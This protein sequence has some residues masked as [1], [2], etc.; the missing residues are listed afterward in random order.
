MRVAFSPHRVETK[1]VPVTA[2][3]WISVL[4]SGA[5]LLAGACGGSGP[6]RPAA[7]DSFPL[8]L[9]T[10]NGSVTIPQKPSRIVSLSATATQDLYA[11]GA[12]PQVA[13][14]DKYSTYPPEAPK[15]SLSGFKPNVEAIAGY[16]P[17][18]VLVSDNT[19]DIAGQLAKLG[20]PTL[21]EPAAADFD[22]MYAQIREIGRAT[23]NAARAD[24]EATRLRDRVQSLVR[25]APKPKRAYRVYHELDQ[26]YF[27]A[28]TKTFVGQVYKQLG[29][30]D[31]ADATPGSKPYP[32]LSAEY[33]ISANP[34]LIVLADTVC[35]KQNADTVR[36]RAG[37]ASVAAVKSGAIVP[38]DDSVAS[39]W[40]P[41]IVEFV[42]AVV[43]AL[44]KL[45]SA[46]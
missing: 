37:W 19:K 30:D 22:G 23:G 3:R 10:A 17:D 18:L 42:Q 13:A 40:G 26:T 24:Q 27:S 4:L 14:V 36:A 35:C 34:D 20:I 6:A 28:T 39:D 43:D 25:S 2:T 45:P 33:I 8:T 41:R 32:Q 46:G 38:V 5:A 7:H 15:T 1:E 44:R 11:V 12:G 29:L 16:K 31:I 9:S 21:V